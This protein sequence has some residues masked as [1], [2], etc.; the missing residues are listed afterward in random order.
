MQDRKYKYLYQL[1]L[2]SI[3]LVIVPVLFFYSV[4]WKKAIREINYVNN[5]YHNNALD[6][7]LGYFTNEVT[8]FKNVIVEFSVKS[9]TSQTD[10]GIFYYGT[11]VM[12]EEA[13]YYWEAASDLQEYG[14][15]FDFSKKVLNLK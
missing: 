7:F 13:Y 4:V 12:E 9:R 1:M 15:K 11:E 6:S 5:E 3:I 14:H 2:T 8:E 10:G